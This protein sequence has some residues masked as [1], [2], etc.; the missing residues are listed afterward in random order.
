[1]EEYDVELI[2][3]LRVIWKGKWIILACLALAV[4]ASI[5]ITWTRPDRYGVTVS[6]RL[7]D[8][9]LTAVGIL[10][11][12]PQDS[13]QGVVGLS[14]LPLLDAVEAVSAST[15]QSGIRLQ[16]AVEAER[17]RVTLSGTSEREKLQDALGALAPAV[18]ERLALW[19]ATR[20][21]QVTRASEMRIAELKTTRERLYEHLTAIGDSDLKDSLVLSLAGR[22]ANLEAQAVQEQVRLET[23]REIMPE[24]LFTLEEIQRSSVSRLGPSRRLPVVMAALLGICVGALLTFFVQYLTSVR[25]R[26][27]SEAGR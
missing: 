6:Y 25:E 14:V 22:W 17:V 18:S 15:L 21:A 23:L 16:A 24:D 2:D 9:L 10:S 7:D 4:A 27:K 8:S 5:A 12:A 20:I 19:V 1:M 3:Y 13:R 26:A 11:T